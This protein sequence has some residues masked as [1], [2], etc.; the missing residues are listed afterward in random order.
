MI[1]ISGIGIWHSACSLY[2]TQSNNSDYYFFIIG[3]HKI[4]SK[5]MQNS[6]KK[7]FMVTIIVIMGFY[8]R[9][10]AH[11]GMGYG[12]HYG[13]GYP[14]YGMHQ[15]GYGGPGFGYCGELS[16]DQIQKLAKE[17]SAFFEATQDLRGR[18]Y[19]KGLELRSELAKENPDANKAAALQKEIS[20][21]KAELGQ[22][23]LNHI[24]NMKKISPEIGRG[25]GGGYGMMGP[26][27]MYGGMMGPWAMGPGYGMGSEMLGPGYGRGPG[28]MGPGYGMGPGM[29]GPG[30]GMGPGLMGPGWGRG[31][32]PYG[33]DRDDQLQS[34]RH[35]GPLEKKDA[36]QI[37]EN[38]IQS[39]RNPNLKLG[40]IEDTGNAFKAQ[41]I[42]KD[43]SLVDEVLID[44]DSGYMRPAY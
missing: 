9:A 17:Q 16:E 20:E 37:V 33:Y 41:I 22:K 42:T 34:G 8:G 25:F 38:Y 28:M 6:I 10:F 39:T 24:L 36:E 14:M 27:M 43:N 18:L 35:M 1:S 4:R 40:K 3:P 30:Y 11:S 32:N 19:Q 26:G 23:R 15:G 5:N 21:M 31:M 12:H 7:I 29:M 44:K 13:W 2:L